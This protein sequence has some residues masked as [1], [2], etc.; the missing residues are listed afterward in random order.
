MISSEIELQI[1]RLEGDE[2]LHRG[3]L[4]G[5]MPKIRQELLAPS[6]TWL[7]QQLQIQ[8]E[9]NPRVV[10]ELGAEKLSLLKKD[11]KALCESLPDIISTVTEDATQWPHNSK[12]RSSV[13]TEHFHQ[14][15]REVVNHLGPILKE[16]NIVQVAD[17]MQ[18]W[19]SHHD[20]TYRV[21]VGTTLIP[22]PASMNTYLITVRE[23]WE[24]SRQLDKAKKD[25]LAA[26]A[27]ELWEAAE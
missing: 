8:L 19:R 17:R 20:G 9:S 14:V 23:L 18:A 5:M 3:S 26:K 13:T 21:G 15:F 1:Q 7:R 22:V 16:Y 11:F 24:I 2:R 27:K 25:L 6:D 4:D 10:V 12:Y